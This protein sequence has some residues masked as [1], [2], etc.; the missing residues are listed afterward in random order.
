MEKRLV[1]ISM[2]ALGGPR[3]HRLAESVKCVARPS[4][5]PN[6]STPDRILI[7]QC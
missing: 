1:H 4:I 2:S 6:I 5:L 7:L 3:F